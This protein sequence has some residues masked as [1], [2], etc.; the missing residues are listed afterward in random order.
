MNT[1]SPTHDG[2]QTVAKAPTKHRV[3]RWLGRDATKE[4]VVY[5][6]IYSQAMQRLTDAGITDVHD[7]RESGHVEPNGA[8]VIPPGET[9][10]LTDDRAPSR[11]TRSG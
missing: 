5:A 4:Y 9:A 7:L 8:L 10:V 3:L 2:E 6:P 1:A 11:E